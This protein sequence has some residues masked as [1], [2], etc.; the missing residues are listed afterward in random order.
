MEAN[1]H[2][3]ADDLICLGSCILWCVDTMLRILPFGSVR[4]WTHR[5]PGKVPGL[6]PMK[7]IIMDSCFVVLGRVWHVHEEACDSESHSEAPI[8]VSG[9]SDDLH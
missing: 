7:K 8:H 3:L 2:N 9:S 4:I 6:C 1:R 5:M